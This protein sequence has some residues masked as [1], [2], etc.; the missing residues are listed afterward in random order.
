MV[1]RFPAAVG[2]SDM[3]RLLGRFAW[4]Y[5]LRMRNVL[6][7]GFLFLFVVAG[8]VSAEPV[9]RRFALSFHTTQGTMRFECPEGWSP[10]GAERLRELVRSGFFTDVAFFRVVEGFVAQFGISGDPAI[11]AKW[12]EAVIED[13]PVVASN[14]AGTLSYATAGPGTRTT[15]LFI[16][17]VD[18]PRLDK[19]G[20]SPVC[21]TADAES[22]EVARKLYSGYG[23]GP[24]FGTGPD[25]DLITKE[26][27]AYLEANF[28]KLD[29]LLSAEMSEGGR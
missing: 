24:P 26:G 27:N 15:Q 6:F 1:P 17:L 25:Q 22:L 23:D 12:A 18:N 28:P 14:L 11:S 20:F 3:P 5:N 2:R 29:Y 21:M 9:P 4:R 19:H 10:L 8:T 13:D 7:P 16:N